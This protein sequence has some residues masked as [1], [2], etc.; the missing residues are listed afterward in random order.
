MQQAA[1]DAITTL[2]DLLVGLVASAVQEMVILQMQIETL[3]QIQD[4]AAE[5]SEMLEI[6]EMEQRV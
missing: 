2:E 4:Q 1:E 6:L 3:L 5:E